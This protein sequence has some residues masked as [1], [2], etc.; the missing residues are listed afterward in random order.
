MILLVVTFSLTSVC[1]AASQSK[2]LIYSSARYRVYQLTT[3]DGKKVTLITNLS[4]NGKRLGGEIKSNRVTTIRRIS[5]AGRTAA[6]VPARSN[7][8]VAFEPGSMTNGIPL[9]KDCANKQ[10]NPFRPVNPFRNPTEIPSTSGTV[11][12]R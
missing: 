6:T 10:I 9:C 3:E 11:T 4:D 7:E 1:M 8:I 2:R 12:P 5:S